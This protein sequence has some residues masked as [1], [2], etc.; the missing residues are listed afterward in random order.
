MKKVIA[1]FTVFVGFT[2]FAGFSFRFASAWAVG[3]C[4][5]LFAGFVIFALLALLASR[6]T[7][8]LPRKDGGCSG[9]VVNWA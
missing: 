8:N 1:G 5:P 2:G 6:W 7:V 3:F 9:T 4:A